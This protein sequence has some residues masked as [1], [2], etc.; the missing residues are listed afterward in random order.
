MTAK[1]EELVV[2]TRA[3]SDE[4]LKFVFNEP[5]G[6]ERP[7]MLS[8]GDTEI[9]L[10]FTAAGATARSGTTLGTG[11]ATSRWISA[12]GTTRTINSTSD[13]ITFYNLAASTVG[14]DKYILLARLGEDWIC[15]WEECS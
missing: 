15:I 10:A 11:T 8:Y 9:V 1:D 13:S 2:F 5:R 7:P 4:I 3:D 14:T 12:S 6:S